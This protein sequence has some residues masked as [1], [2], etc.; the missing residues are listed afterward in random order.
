[1]RPITDILSAASRAFRDILAEIGEAAPLG[2]PLLLL[3]ERGTGKST[4]ARH[5][6]NI[7]GR[8]GRFI[9]KPVPWIQPGMEVPTLSGH[10]R[11]SFTGAIRDS[12]GLIEQADRGTLFLDELGDAS[13]WLQSLLLDVLEG[14]TI[15]RFGE[16]LERPVDVRLVAATNADL[17]R[18]AFEGRFRFDLLDRFGYFVYR[19]PTLAERREDIPQLAQGFLKAMMVELDVGTLFEFSCDAM[20][21]LLRASWPGNIRQLESL[22]AAAAVGARAEGEVVIDVHHLP[23]EFLESLGQ[24]S[25]PTQH[26]RKS[27]QN[28]LATARGNKSAAARQMGVSRTTLYNRLKGGKSRETTD[29]DEKL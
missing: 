4:V 28:A 19:L 24:R 25:K 10:S 6:H 29:R 3:G 20:D 12:K 23:A 13:L 2:R 17:K 15:T 1:M 22:C 14:K 27:T 9:G 5:V 8:R 18:L 26:R 11:G 21:L 16:E 7:S